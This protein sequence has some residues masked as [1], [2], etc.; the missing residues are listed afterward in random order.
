ML[1]NRGKALVA[2]LMADQVLDPDERAVWAMFVTAMRLRTPE[3]IELV[4]NTGAEHF[5]LELGRGQP[6]YEALKEANEPETLV[7]WA[8]RNTP[9]LLENFSLTSVPR[10]VAGDVAR[11][12]N[13]MAWHSLNFGGSR[14]RLLCSDRP[15]VFTTGIDDPDCVVALPLSP[16]HTFLSFYARSKAEKALKQYGPNV[17]GAALNKNVVTQ[18]KERAFCLSQHDAPKTFYQKY[19]ASTARRG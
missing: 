18:A 12:I 15:C 17:I 6:E 11:K 16:N 7:E 10:V 4:R 2:K 1:D 14:H 9:G 13:K 19:L 5:K 3:N 8:E